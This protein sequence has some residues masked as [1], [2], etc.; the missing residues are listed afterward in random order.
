M[1][2]ITPIENKQFNFNAYED[3]NLKEIDIYSLSS[4]E[5]IQYQ[6]FEAGMSY[7]I[8]LVKENGK[9]YLFDASRFIENC[10]ISGT[11]I[12]NPLTQQTIETFEIHVS[13]KEAPEF[14]LYMTKE[15]VT[16]PP[17]HLPILWSDTSRELS[18]R[19][20]LM[21]AYGKAF[22][23]QDLQK[24]LLVY[25]D[26][27]AA[28]CSEAMLRLVT[29][30]M[31]L[32]QK[33]NAI[34]WLHKSLNSLYLRVQ[35]LFFC[36]HVFEDYQDKKMAFKAYKLAAE[37]K[38]MIG[39]GELIHH[40]EQGIGVEMNLEEAH[41]WRQYLPEGWKDS[42]IS[43]FFDHLGKIKYNYSREGYP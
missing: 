26:A 40:F 13:S 42:S 31:G 18:N 32:D 19:F 8:C 15:D 41:K 16:K 30:Y 36:A 35:D 12:K 28:G 33:E 17:N 37:K 43:D 24:T 11:V 25:E 22:E 20:D 29:K 27:A 14:K 4:F 23:T 34:K 38:N 1:N 9:T 21:L 6:R 10:V 7:Y 5:V 3:I 39:L 2:K